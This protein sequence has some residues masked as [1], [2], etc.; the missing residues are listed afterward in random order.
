MQ[1]SLEEPGWLSGSTRACPPYPEHIAVQ[2]ETGKE[3]ILP[4]SSHFC[5]AALDC[6]CGCPAPSSGGL[7]CPW[8]VPP[9]CSSPTSHQH[10]AP[11]L[12]GSRN[13]RPVG[14]EPALLPSHMGLTAPDGTTLERGVPNIPATC[15]RAPNFPW[16]VAS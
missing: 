14:R 12:R 8:R 1:S 10:Q 15:L 2:Q 13:P 5:F 7:G 11:N 9:G 4:F 3:E 6:T 16:I